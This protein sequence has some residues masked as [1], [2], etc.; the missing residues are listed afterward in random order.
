MN[1]DKKLIP[2][3]WITTCCGDRLKPCKFC[4]KDMWKSQGD[5]DHGDWEEEV[6]RCQNCGNTIYVELPD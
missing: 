5:K 4:N 3:G 1:T 6:F 2:T